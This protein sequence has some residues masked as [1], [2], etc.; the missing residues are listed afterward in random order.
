[1]TRAADVSPGSRIR[2]ICLPSYESPLANY[3]PE[4]GTS[5]YVRSNS[6]YTKRKS[7]KRP[8]PNPDTASKYLEKLNNLTKIM[9]PG[10]SN[11]KHKNLRYNIRVSNNSNRQPDKKSDDEDN[12]DIEM[13]N[14][15][16]V[17]D[18]VTLDSVV[19][20]IQTNIN[21]GDANNNERS[22][23]KLMFGE[24]IDPFIEE[25]NGLDMKDECY[26]TGWG[27]DQTNGSLTDVL[28]EAEVP[29]LPLNI[30]RDRYSLSLPL[31]EGHLC[32]GSTDGSTG[33]CVVSIT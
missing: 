4:K 12:P 18:R 11:K 6:E 8:K 9:F 7:V 29:V 19:K 22:D 16:I 1:M 2:T 23:K 25:D 26:T 15:D 28:L 32:A 3:S 31:N 24:E 27:R 13:K 5:F 20:L 17:Y 33:A 30:C 10:Y 14:R 21:E